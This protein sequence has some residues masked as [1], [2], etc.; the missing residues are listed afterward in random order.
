MDPD[1]SGGSPLGSSRGFE[2]LVFPLQMSTTMR[3][4]TSKGNETH[5]HRDPDY[6][7]CPVC[8]H[9]LHAELLKSSEPE[10]LVCNH[11][12]FVF[13]LDPK[14]VTGVIGTI[15]GKIV[16][17]RRGIEPSYGKWAFPG[18]YVDRGETL[19]N[20]AIRETKEEV[21]LD[22]EIEALLNVYSYRGEPVIVIVYVV[23]IVGGELC[24]GDE[25]IEVKTFSPKEIPW[26]ELAFS[27]TRDALLDYVKLYL[28]DRN[29]LSQS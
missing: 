14:V 25:T 9:A 4:P 24:P 6:Q 17:L 18:G 1:R 15:D 20:A 7:F 21:N 22:V 12:N 16:L 28:N 8:G 11:C 13:Y 3:E 23:R 5:E 2:C 27:S 19:E 29:K 10:R 26:Q